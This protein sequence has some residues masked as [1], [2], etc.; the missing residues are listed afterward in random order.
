MDMALH[1]VTGPVRISDDSAMQKP[2]ANAELRVRLYG[3]PA[4]VLPDGRVV[5]LERRAAALLALAALEPGISRLRVASLLWPDSN[6]P[7]RNLR[8]QL[9][10]FRQLFDHPLVEGDS[11]LSVNEMLIEAPDDLSPA[12]LLAGHEYEDCEEFAAWLLQ[13]RE[14]RHAR[15]LETARQQLAGSEEAGDLDAALA[16]ANALLALDHHSESH[17]RELMRL[18][19]LRGDSAAGLTAYRRLSEMLAADFDTP[20]VCGERRTGRC[21]A[22]SCAAQR[23]H[24]CTALGGRAERS[25]A[26]SVETAASACRS[27]KRKRRG[28]AA[29]DRRPRRT[30]RRRSGPRQESPDGGAPGRHERDTLCGWPPWRRRCTL[31]NSGAAAAAAAGRGR[32]RSGLANA[33]SP[34]PHHLV[35]RAGAVGFF[36]K[37]RGGIRCAPRAQ[38]AA[39]RRDGHRRFRTAPPHNVQVVALDDLHFADEATIDLI[40]SLAA[41]AEPPRCWLLAARPAELSPAAGS[42]GLR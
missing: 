15:L 6:D 31:R 16:A 5:A 20:A 33:R 39:P 12:P 25:T 18:N 9:L 22:Q 17:H 38:P 19:Y 23:A 37:C 14:A 27:R 10:R 13:Q 26:G 21:A 36:R 41:Q 42:C 24:G 34:R 3:D 29:L 2:T 1:T 28:G 11:A 30:A 4:V 8:Q 35:G 32:G 7:R 40:A